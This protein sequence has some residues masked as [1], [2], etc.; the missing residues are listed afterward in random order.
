MLQED[1]KEALRLKCMSGIHVSKGV[2]CH[3]DQLR[4]AQPTTC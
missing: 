4:T 2:K 1:F 3:E